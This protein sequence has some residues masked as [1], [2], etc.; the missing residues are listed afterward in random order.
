MIS[1]GTTL[2]PNL[3]SDLFNKLEDGSNE[4]KGRRR[5]N[6]VREVR[7]YLGNDTLVLETDISH[8]VR[9]GGAVTNNCPLQK[10]VGTWH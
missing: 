2:T 1:F 5:E 3:G 9:Q 10:R 4:I 6:R 8:I 7:G